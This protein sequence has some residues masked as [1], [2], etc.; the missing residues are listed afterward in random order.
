MNAINQTPQRKHQIT[1]VNEHNISNTSMHATHH[2]VHNNT[3]QN[4]HDTPH[5]TTQC[6]LYMAMHNKLLNQKMMMSV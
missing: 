1:H 4:I 5:H 3:I 6:T 2:T